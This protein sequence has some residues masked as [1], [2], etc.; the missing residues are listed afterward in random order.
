MSS[1]TRFNHYFFYALSK[2]Q[3]IIYG[4]FAWLVVDAAAIAYFE[5]MPFADALYFTFVTGLTI[6]YGDIAPVTLAGRV[7]AILTGL[8]GILITGLVVAVAVYA[9]RKTMEP[10]TDS[11]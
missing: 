4:L 11:H 2:I 1:F 10:P 9:L 7:V 5:K 3:G 8:L 6:G